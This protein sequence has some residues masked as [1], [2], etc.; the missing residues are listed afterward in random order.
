MITQSDELNG[1]KNC[2]RGYSSGELAKVRQVL[3]N[4]Y[5]KIKVRAASYVA[6]EGKNGQT[7]KLVIP[8]T[9]YSAAA[10]RRG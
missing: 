9:K 2:A 8:M 3:F 6:A 7:V 10:R 5:A 1:G 4:C